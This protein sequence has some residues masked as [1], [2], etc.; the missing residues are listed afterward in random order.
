MR[1]KAM[2]YFILS[3]V[4]LA[5]FPAS[6]HAGVLVL[7]G[8]GGET[9]RVQD[10]KDIGPDVHLMKIENAGS[11]WDGKVFAVTKRT[12]NGQDRYSFDYT[13]ELSSGPITRTYQI[14]DQS[15][16]AMVKGTSVDSYKMYLPWQADDAVDLVQDPDLTA[17]YDR[18]PMAESY[19]K[20]PFT[21]TVE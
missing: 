15:G 11:A 2:K 13:I 9:V 12:V 3:F 19:A 1:F 8:T 17:A 18:A 5:L 7:K 6:A 4:A 20:T 16:G 10:A 21:P 14:M